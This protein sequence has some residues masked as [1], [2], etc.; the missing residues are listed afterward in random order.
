MDFNNLL[1]FLVELFV[2]LNTLRVVMTGVNL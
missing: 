1:D 2:A